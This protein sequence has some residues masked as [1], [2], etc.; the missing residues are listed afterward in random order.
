[1]MFFCQCCFLQMVWE[2]LCSGY[3]SQLMQH[4]MPFIKPNKLCYQ[5]FVTNFAKTTEPERVFNL[6]G[7][8]HAKAFNCS[9]QKLV[10]SPVPA[11]PEFKD[12]VSETDE[13]ILWVGGY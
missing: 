11:Y 4:N 2:L 6:S 5:N 7:H 1:M 10:E 8:Q 13:S 9:Q 3:M 12:F